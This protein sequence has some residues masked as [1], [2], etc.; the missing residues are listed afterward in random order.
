MSFQRTDICIDSDWFVR[1]QRL[2][3]TVLESQ[4]TRSHPS[5]NGFLLS[6]CKYAT[7]DTQHRVWAIDP[8][9]DLTAWSLHFTEGMPYEPNCIW[10]S[11]RT[12]V[13]PIKAN[14]F[15][16]RWMNDRV[17]LHSTMEYFHSSLSPSFSSWVA[18]RK[19]MTRHAYEVTVFNLQFCPLVS[20]HYLGVPGTW[21][22]L[23]WESDFLSDCQLIEP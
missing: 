6:Y 7:G 14:T 15:S 4:G 2:K 23:K 13:C 18:V 16:K 21:L 9:G 5:F 17:Q 8:L 22:D 12:S 3:S 20:E 19:W 1:I 10:G 11:D